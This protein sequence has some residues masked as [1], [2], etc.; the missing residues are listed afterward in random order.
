MTAT[1]LVLTV[2][3]LQACLIHGQLKLNTNTNMCCLPGQGIK[4]GACVNCPAG[5]APESPGDQG[6]DVVCSFCDVCKRAYSKEGS[7]ICSMCGALP[8]EF[9]KPTTETCHKCPTGYVL[10]A[11]SSAKSAD[12]AC[13]VPGAVGN[14]KNER[15]RRHLRQCQNTFASHLFGNDTDCGD[16]VEHTSCTRCDTSQGQYSNEIGKANCK[17]CPN[18]KTVNVTLTGNKTLS[19]SPPSEYPPPPSEEPKSEGGKRRALAAPNP[20]QLPQGICTLTEAEFNG[21][22]SEEVNGAQVCEKCT[23]F[24]AKCTEEIFCIDCPAGKAGEAG[25]CTTCAPGRYQSESGKLNCINCPAGK[26]KIVIVGPT[27]PGSECQPCGVGFHQDEIGKSICKG[28]SAGNYQNKDGEVSCEDCE[29]GRYQNANEAIECIDCDP[30]KAKDTVGGGGVDCADCG[31]GQFQTFPG[32]TSCEACANGQSQP[33]GGQ[34]TC[35]E[36]AEGKSAPSTGFT[37]W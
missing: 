4:D 7:V 36:C 16:S 13:P 5:K 33:T 24:A 17:T 2:L 3:L 34:T 35:V 26:A 14:D 21:F 6:S 12:L 32:S 29:A 25:S 30:G 15:R 11:L 10:P 23:A 28:C 27:T 31:A 19:P 8:G 37:A 20:N 9:W 22:P 1:A 18:G